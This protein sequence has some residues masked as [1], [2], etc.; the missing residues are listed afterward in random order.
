MTSNCPTSLLVHSPTYS[1]RPQLTA[2]HTFLH[3]LLPCNPIRNS[4]RGLATYNLPPNL[5]R[6][7]EVL[8]LLA[9]VEQK[10]SSTHQSPKTPATPPPSVYTTAIVRAP[11]AFRNRAYG[12]PSASRDRRLSLHFPSNSPRCCIKAIVSYTRIHIL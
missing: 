12:T 1:R 2:V 7:R 9:A 3:S 4:T 6:A 10:Y 5:H 8:D 11:A